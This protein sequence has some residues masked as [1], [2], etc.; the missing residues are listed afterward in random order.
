MS[1]LVKGF[2]TDSAGWA[3]GGE[4]RTVLVQPDK[5][6]AGSEASAKKRI[7]AV[8]RI[9][10]NR[11][12]VQEILGICHK[13]HAILLLKSHFQL[14]HAQISPLRHPGVDFESLFL[15]FGAKAVP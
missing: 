15:L 13:N 8:I 10:L 5:N 9:K 3:V 12:R 4:G 7:S 6:Q 11:R 1:R 2:S 14:I